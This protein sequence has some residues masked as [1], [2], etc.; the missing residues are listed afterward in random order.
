MTRVPATLSDAQAVLRQ[1]APQTMTPR[2]DGY[3][4]GVVP[5]TEGGLE[6]RWVLISSAP[7]HPHAQ[8][9]VNKQGLTPGDQDVHTLKTRCRTTV[10]C[11][12][13]AQPA[14]AT[15]AQRLRAT[16]LHQAALRPPPRDDTRGRPGQGACPAQ[17]ISM[18]AGA[19]ASSI[20]APRPRG[21]QQSGFM[22]ATTALDH[23]QL[24]PQAL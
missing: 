5:S 9:P 1:A 3:R 19:L 18:S 10:A 7:R 2:A 6:Q 24:P 13:E 20:A 11:E 12:A 21:D 17:V 4:Y 23:T 14:L 16:C 22:L 15:F 8:H